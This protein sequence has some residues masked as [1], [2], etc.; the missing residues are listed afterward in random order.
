HWT[1]YLHSP[2]FIIH[3]TTDTLP[4]LQP[5]RH[6]QRPHLLLTDQRNRHIVAPKLHS[7][8]LCVVAELIN[9]KANTDMR[10]R[11]ILIIA[12]VAVLTLPASALAQGGG[13]EQNG[14]N[15]QA[16]TAQPS[17]Q[18]PPGWK[19]CPR[20]QNNEDRR[21]DAVEYKIQGHA[22]D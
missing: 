2:Q 16:R 21:Q 22:F 9:D 13:Q 10:N 4:N 20:C 1:S 18:F 5:N 6:R 8:H 11:T 15:A 3:S 19:P 14:P 17:I 12:L 7:I